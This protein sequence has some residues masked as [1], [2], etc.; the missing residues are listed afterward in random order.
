LA[1]N[2]YEGMFI[3]DSGRYGRDPE[4]VSGAISKII[5]EAGGEVLVSR[6]WEER[7]L[8]YMINGQRKGTYWLTYFRVEGQQLP[9]ITRQSDLNDN[10]LRSLLLTVDPRIVDALVAHATGVSAK[11][12]DAA[13]EAK[14]DEAK[15]DEKK[16]GDAEPAKAA[17]ETPEV[18]AAVND[19]A[20]KDSEA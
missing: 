16:P 10:I 6:L 17:A 12:E 20:E 11:P 18:A 19:G 4:G 15:P 1:I 2:V 8:A 9:K 3:F 5:E 13:D 7:R 14:P